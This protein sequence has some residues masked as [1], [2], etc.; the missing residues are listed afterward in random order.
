MKEAPVT[1]RPV[2]VLQGW[3]A[4]GIGDAVFFEGCLESMERIW[5]GQIEY[6]G[7]SKSGFSLGPY[8]N[9]AFH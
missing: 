5:T 8:L 9:I 4:I 7:R 3:K 2:H 6:F 1:A